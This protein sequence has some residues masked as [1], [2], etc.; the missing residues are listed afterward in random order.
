MN[1]CK[2][3]RFR[4]SNPSKSEYLYETNVLFKLRTNVFSTPFVV[5]ISLSKRTYEL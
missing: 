5:G 1:F 3:G 2:P 4:I